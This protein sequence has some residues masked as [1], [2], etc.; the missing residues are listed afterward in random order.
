MLSELLWPLS[1]VTKYL[2]STFASTVNTLLHPLGLDHLPVPRVRGGRYQPSAGAEAMATRNRELSALLDQAVDLEGAPGEAE[3]GAAEGGAAAGAEAEPEDDGD[4]AWHGG[5]AAPM[6]LTTAPGL[7]VECEAP[8]AMRCEQC[9]DEYCAVCFQALHRKGKR[10]KHTAVAVEAAAPAVGPRERPGAAAAAAAAVSSGEMYSPEWFV[11][12]SKYIPLRLS[13]KQRKGLRLL[14]SALKV[15]DYTDKIDVASNRNKAK[16]V[17]SQLRDVCALLSGTVVAADYAQGQELVHSRN[18]AEQ[19]RFFVALFEVGRRHKIMNPDA[20]REEYGKLVYLLQD[21]NSAEVQDLLQFSCVGGLETVH[22]KLSE[23][24]V[25]ELMSDP[26]VKTATMEILPEG[27]HRG[28][29]QREIK[30]KEQAVKVLSRKYARRHFDDEDIQL[31]LYSIADNHAYLRY[32]RDPV[33]KMIRLLRTHFKPGSIDGAYSLAITGD[34]DGARL[35]HSH[36][37]QYSYVLQSLT[38]WREI[39]QDMFKL[40]TLAEQDLL[41][42]SSPY[43]LKDTGQ[44]LQRVQECPRISK[45]MREIVHRVQEQSGGWVGS[46]VVHLGDNNVPNSLIF[47]DKYNQVSRFLQPIV[48]CIDKLPE[49][50]GKDPSVKKYLDETFGG[51]TKLTKVTTTN[52]I[53]PHGLDQQLASLLMIVHGCAQDILLDFFKGGF[54]GSGQSGHAPQ[55]C[56]RA[57]ADAWAVPRLQ[58]PTTFSTR[59]LASTGG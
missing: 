56:L 7:C 57:G 43:T 29:I 33:D 27:K 35:T 8:A 19:E 12:R 6:M 2:Y 10:A 48:L 41:D 53:D 15:C 42:P 4:G 18:F 40:W 59:A 9:D 32:N 23:A 11:E 34:Q 25:V 1:Y 55:H 50:A 20:M 28:Q 44:G 54:D 39:A 26:L 36:D 22:K 3:G 58:A 13:M 21:A 51:V 52:A 31:C 5:Q 49:I 46:S 38:L 16:R 14:Q 30:A 24:G 37:R 47:I 45:A 17:A